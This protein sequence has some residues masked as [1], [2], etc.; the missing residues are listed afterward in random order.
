MDDLESDYEIISLYLEE[1]NYT[2]A[3]VLANM[4][5][6]LYGLTGDDLAEHD[7]KSAIFAVSQKHI[8]P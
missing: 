6:T 2:D 4:L 8:Q 3:I 5:P 1:G 7:E